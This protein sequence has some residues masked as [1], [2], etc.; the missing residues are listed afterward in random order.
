MVALAIVRLTSR[1]ESP[2]FSK[3]D[4]S[5]CQ[6]GPHDSIRIAE[7]FGLVLKLLGRAEMGGCVR[8]LKAR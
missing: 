2:Y 6:I 5:F 3:L 4:S 8:V 1:G 7:I